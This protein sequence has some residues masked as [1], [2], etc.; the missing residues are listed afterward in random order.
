MVFIISNGVQCIFLFSKL[1]FLRSINWFSLIKS[2]LL[3][4]ELFFECQKGKIKTLTSP[5]SKET[6]NSANVKQRQSKTAPLRMNTSNT[7]LD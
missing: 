6:K 3:Y 2:A 1:S 7:H 4:C 5:S